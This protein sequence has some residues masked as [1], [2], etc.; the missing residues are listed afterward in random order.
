MRREASSF[1]E[2]WPS[3][4]VHLQIVVVAASS[5]ACSELNVSERMELA[6]SRS[7]VE[8]RATTRR[9]IR[10]INDGYLE[11]A[12]EIGRAL[13]KVHHRRRP[14]DPDAIRSDLHAVSSPSANLERGA[15]QIMIRS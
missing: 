1:G 9:I 10:R 6:L 3:G 7:R 4:R 14:V 15:G 2:N 8:L 13:G 12:R 5:A 11:R